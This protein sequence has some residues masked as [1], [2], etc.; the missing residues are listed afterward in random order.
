MKW[1][2]TVAH[3]PIV[4]HLPAI[5]A[6][7]QETS[8]SILESPPGSGKT[9]ILPLYLLD[10]PWLQGKKILVLQ[11]RR[12][13]AR[14]VASHMSNL[15][16]QQVG[17]TVGY[18]IRMERKISAKT[19]I[20]IITEGLL[21]RRIISEPDLSD[22]GLVIFDEFHERSV[23]ADLGL[24]LLLEVV[25]NL[26]SDLKVLIMS[27]TLGESGALAPLAN[28]WRYSF[29]LAPHKL[30]ISYLHGEARQPVWQQTATAIRSALEQHEGDL[31][32]FL[33][34]VYEIDRCQGELERTRRS[35]LLSKLFGE[36]DYAEQL[37]ALLP[38]P[39]GRRKII[40]AT[41]IAETSLTIEGVR[42]V[43]DSG[44]HKV[45]RTESSGVTTLKTERI[46]RDAADQRAGRAARTAAGV[47]IRLW[48]EHEQRALRPQREPE[49]LRADLTPVVLDLA[50][51]GVRNCLEFPWL[52]KPNLKALEDALATLRSI[53]AIDG[54]GAITESGKVISR[55][56]AH[57]RLAKMCLDARIF[58]YEELAAS[59]LTLL[60]ERDILAGRKASANL[61]DRLE[62]LNNSGG[63]NGA[64]RRLRELRERWTGRIRALPASQASQASQALRMPS[65]VD[66]V[67]LLL[68]SAFPE[69]IAKRREPKS[70]RYL[71]ANGSGATVSVDDAL[72]ECEYI[73]VADMHEG[74]GDGRIF[75]AAPFN[76]ELFDGVLSGLISSNTRSAFNE[77][78]GTLSRFCS[79][80]CGAI[81]VTERTVPL[82]D[83]DEQREAFEEWLTSA[84]GFAKI[85]FNATS[86]L[87]RQRISWLRQIGFSD[88]LPDLSD[89]ALQNKISEWLAPFLPQR[90]SV[91]TLT[92][93]LVQQA[94]EALLS[95]QQHR[96]VDL[97]APATITLP[98]GKTRPLRYSNNE[99]P[100]VEVILQDLFGLPDTPT[101]GSSRT[102]LILH[103][104]SPARRPVQVTSDLASFWRSGYQEVRKELRARYPKHKWPE[105]P[106]KGS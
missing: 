104:L 23:H 28:A 81:T 7:I 85:P 84:A 82:L 103:L 49:I 71:L 42:I 74:L 50:A 101:V 77:E 52:T 69:R 90:C 47:C 3:L 53:G 100:I 24:S 5:A 102:P 70:P 35:E 1:L 105:D 19:R 8:I 43:V 95:W 33:P 83:P 4:Q 65:A 62:L 9:S 88:P 12:I 34:G 87:L 25:A 37:K 32:A 18:Q 68:A 76:P 99:A 46:S 51:W 17:Q 45:A 63:N 2:A 14:S 30:T 91:S 57:P 93:A 54:S 29:S 40:L 97:E 38:E 96:T 80:S 86:E 44:L 79:S 6:G 36:L 41:P 11:P 26:R 15:L 27:A 98:N 72:K 60:E 22:V 66:A 31:L 94:L 89:Q 58:G 67:G 13:A 75:L 92:P 48:S 61:L 10:E 39:S 59:I 64:V 55:F 16:Q 73:V 78:R 21:T 20:E 106:I 56:G